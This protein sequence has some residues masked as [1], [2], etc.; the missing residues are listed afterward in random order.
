MSRVR[1]YF[2]L[3]FHMNFKN[4][5][6]AI[7]KIHE[8]SKKSRLIIFFDMIICSIKYQAGY[9]DYK[10]FYF[11]NLKP[12][13]RK[14]FITRGVNNNY[15]KTMNDPAYYYYFNDK[16]EF[17][18]IFN[19]YIKRD[20]IYLH[21]NIEY[22]K[23]FLKRHKE[24]IVKPVSLQCG[25]GIEK[26]II[27]PETD[28]KELYS[29]LINSKQLLVEEYIKQSNVMNSLY[30]NS[31]NTIRIVTANKNNKTKIL[32]KAIRIG[33]KG[34]VVDNFNHGGMYSIINDA[35]IITKPAI[36]KEGKVYEKHPT[37]NTEIVGFIIPYFKEAIKMAVNAS[38]VIPQVGLVGWDIAITDKG[39][40]II[41]GNQLPGYDIYQSKIHL[42][43][44]GT[45]IKAIFDDAIYKDKKYSKKF[46]N[47]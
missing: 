27:S 25:K 29:N 35:G 8:R 15:I 16:V 30:P 2:N 45:G 38:K 3:L 13:Q 22:F 24:I 37:T 10:V 6:T 42:N 36:D 14:T 7:D 39:P 18:K 32:F 28:I 31:V 19:K 1:Y 26:I 40:L 5:F 17:N 12:Y 9:M 21:D 20:Y 33:N 11:E 41:E 46:S 23:K 34:N 43:A 44:D 4:M 47:K